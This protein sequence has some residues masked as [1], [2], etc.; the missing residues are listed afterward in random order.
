MATMRSGLQ[1]G[2]LV[3]L[4]AVVEVEHDRLGGAEF[5]LCPRP[6][7]ERLAAEPVGDRDRHDA[8]RQQ[9]VLLG[10][11]GADDAL[12]WRRDGGLTEDVLDW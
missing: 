4:D 6:Y 7:A 11:A 12:G 2:D 10:E 9:V 8:E 5:G 3:D 1:R